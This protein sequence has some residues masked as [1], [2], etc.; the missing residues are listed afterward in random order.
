MLIRVSDRVLIIL[1][2]EMESRAQGFHLFAFQ[3]V[4]PTS[5]LV[6][7]HDARDEFCGRT[8]TSLYL[9]Y[10]W[11]D[12][13][14]DTSLSQF[15]TNSVPSYVWTVLADIKS[16]QPSIKLYVLP[17]SPPGWMKDSGTMKGGSLQSQYFT[18]YANYLLKAVQAF[19]SKGY[20]V[21]A[22]S[23]QVGLQS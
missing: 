5:L 21:Y 22:L 12:T 17:W 20:S 6:V 4:L 18:T 10:S 9:A 7:S 19:G 3:S 15:N 8:L 1:K 23:L 2:S 16:I 14:G 13:S 11:D